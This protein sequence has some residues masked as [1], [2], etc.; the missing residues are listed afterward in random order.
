MSAFF[1]SQ[2]LHSHMSFPIPFTI[3][4][5]SGVTSAHLWQ[6]VFLHSL[7]RVPGRFSPDLFTAKSHVWQ[8]S[9]AIL[10]V[11]VEGVS[12]GVGVEDDGGLRACME[13][14]SAGS[15]ELGIEK[16]KAF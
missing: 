3:S 2:F 5:K 4:Q 9:T 8:L 16:G 13:A 15:G 1:P 12:I 14:C 11:G 6:N 10:N 7:H